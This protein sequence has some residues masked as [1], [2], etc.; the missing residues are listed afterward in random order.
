[1]NESTTDGQILLSFKTSD[2]SVETFITTFYEVFPKII[3]F[4]I[5]IISLKNIF[6]IYLTNNYNIIYL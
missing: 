5:K 4:Y 3:I 6:I 1:M 2:V